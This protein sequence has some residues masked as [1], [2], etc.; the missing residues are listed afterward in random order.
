MKLVRSAL[1]VSAVALVSLMPTAAHADKY[2]HTDATGDVVSFST[3]ASDAAAPEQVNGDVVRSSVRHRARKVVLTMRY[4]DLNGSGYTVHFY[5]IHTSKM[6]RH[7][8]LVTFP[9]HHSGKVVMTNKAGTPVHCR[10]TRNID[11]TANTATVGIPRSCLG[12]PRWVKVGMAMITS[13]TQKFST[14]FADDAG[15]DGDFNSPAWSPR[16]YR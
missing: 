14:G 7:V 9:G 4:R 1:M 12:R 3:G 13:P 11:Y 2:V 5:A 10:V 15:T 16:V 6:T 8:S